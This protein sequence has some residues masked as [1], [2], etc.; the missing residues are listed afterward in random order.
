MRSVRHFLLRA[1]RAGVQ[2]IVGEQRGDGDDKTA[3]RGD[4]RFSDT[5]RDGAGGSRNVSAAERAEGAHH[6]GNRAEE[7]EE[8]GGGDDGVERRH[9]LREAAEFL[10]GSADERVGEGEFLVGEGRRECGR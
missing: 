2:E 3:G 7:A 10:T 1:L 6:A 4:E 5:T 9:T 8:R